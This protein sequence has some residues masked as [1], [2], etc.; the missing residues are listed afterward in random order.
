[1]AGKHIILCRDK[2]RAS[3][4]RQWLLLAGAK[5]DKRQEIIFD[6][7]S[8]P[9]EAGCIAYS[10]LAK[11]LDELATAYSGSANPSGV[12]VVV[13]SVAPERL[14]VATDYCSWDSIVA[15]LI[16]SF[17][18]F[19][20][21]FGALR[22]PSGGFPHREHGLASLVE[23]VPGEPLFD[24]SGL[25][26]WVRAKTIEALDSPQSSFTLPRRRFNA[27]SLDDEAECAY[28]LAYT[29]YRFG[30]KAV[31][32]LSY[33]EAKLRLR[34]VAVES[35]A[36]GLDQLTRV[37]G[38][39]FR[40][41]FEDLYIAYPDGPTDGTRLSFLADRDKPEVF[42]RLR[43]AKC[44]MFVSSGVDE[45]SSATSSARSHS[46][47]EHIR[48]CKQTGQ[49]V[50]TASKPL[51]GMFPFWK[52]CGVLRWLEQAW[53]QDAPE[54]A[55]RGL[56]PFRKAFAPGFLWPPLEA[57]SI[58]EHGRHSAP[59]KVL[60]IARHLID[61]AES[62]LASGTSSVI[63]A[64]RGAVFASD[65]LELL[66]GRDPT[67]SLEALVLKHQCEV[68]A[69]C[70]FAGV[71]YG[72]DLGSRFREIERTI[73]HIGLCYSRTMRR[74][75]EI[76]AELMI[77][78]R[79][80]DCFESYHELDEAETCRKRVRILHR[81]A[82]VKKGLQRGNVLI[83]VVWPFRAYA[84]AL[85]GSMTLFAGMI[86]LWFLG[87]GFA[88]D[89]AMQYSP[90]RW[91]DELSDKGLY[92]EVREAPRA[93]LRGSLPEFRNVQ[94]CLQQSFKAM[95]GDDLPAHKEHAGNP[96]I[97]VLL[98]LAKASGLF[99]LGIFLSHLYTLISRR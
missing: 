10:L 33:R 63:A 26:D 85:M 27:V 83:L 99:H 60:L 23:D 59:G 42:G 12:V 31:V 29:A 18:H 44:R 66:G 13:D 11:R 38:S 93:T 56:P 16:L 9:R 36:A 21:V 6:P 61:R 28:Y 92:V 24:H 81:K 96:L 7:E 46:N 54:Y 73:H 45:L 20:W 57:V 69:E 95:V 14:S 22:G 62:L 77:L 55:Q 52:R 8:E 87:V 39:D 67:T 79:L 78:N 88:V 65:A 98:A 37:A 25:R 5:P 64:V 90:N 74:G 82:W 35:E 76:N 80:I 97:S 17:P 34:A 2:I 51:S 58:D 72:Q 49:M 71:E 48:R 75:F 86:I 1:M 3:A 53:T 84:E 47:G 68:I 50:E 91:F 4:L 89:A 41:S 43:N 40:L 19:R 15:M 32:P 30:F 94:A 70:H